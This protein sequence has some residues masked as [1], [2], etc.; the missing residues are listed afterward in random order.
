MAYANDVLEGV[1]AD[2]SITNEF[3]QGVRDFDLE[4]TLDHLQGIGML[5]LA[6]ADAVIGE[7]GI[8]CGDGGVDVT[9]AW[10]NVPV[11]AIEC[12]T[13]GQELYRFR[14]LGCNGV[15]WDT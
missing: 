9:I 8:A 10:R 12:V 13:M 4:G 1:R 5:R 3:D 7:S 2:S 15:G 11:C 14:F 6:D